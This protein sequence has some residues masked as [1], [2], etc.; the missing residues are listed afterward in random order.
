[1]FPKLLQ[2][3]SRFEFLWL[4]KGGELV[5]GR[6]SPLSNF[7]CLRCAPL[8]GHCSSAP[9]PVLAASP[10]SAPGAL[11]ASG[12]RRVPF[13]LLFIL[14]QKSVGLGQCFS[15]LQRSQGPKALDKA[16]PLTAQ[17]PSGQLYVKRSTTKYTPNTSQELINYFEVRKIQTGFFLWNRWMLLNE[18]F[19][20]MLI[21]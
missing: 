19:V 20:G 15:D 5:E 2:Y 8:Q 1:M 11:G 10:G 16:F 17:L 18:L 6:E 13:P 12:R 4:V 9:L 14:P 3:A 21:F 7:C